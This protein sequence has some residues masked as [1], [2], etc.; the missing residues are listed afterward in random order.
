MNRLR[1][2]LTAMTVVAAMAAAAQ[3]PNV[4]NP[5][6]PAKVTFAGNTVSLDRDDMYE[7]LDRELTAMAYTHGNTLLTIKRANRYFP[8]MAPILK[9]NGVPLD[10]LYL[11]CI[12]S[13]LNPRALS[14]A[15]AAGFWQLMPATAKEFGLEVNN[16]VDE[17]YN[18]K[19][20]T[21]AACRYL[22]RAYSR[23][24][25]WE[26]VAASYNGGMARISREL[27]AQ[28]QNTAYNLY[29]TDET[30]RYMFRLL[31]M[32]LIMTRPADYGFSLK[33]NQ[34]YRAAEC[35]PVKVS[36]PVDDWQ[37]WAIDHGTT[38]MALRD[39]NPWIR[40]KSL[41]NKTGKTYTVMVPKPGAQMRSRQ[42][43]TVYDRN[44]IKD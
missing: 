11:A 21:E 23:Y 17:R 9:R 32:K 16:F 6:I 18:L 31:A 7:R 2:I 3:F 25:N 34:L 20:A 43:P 29:L 13:T 15:G 10:M 35:T 33:A 27:Q 42:K 38:Y 24:G 1:N 40:A 14:P 28:G 26:S 19:K 22:K 44:W 30:S 5:E 12:E 37:Q 8:V 36:G 41:P 4:V 39:H